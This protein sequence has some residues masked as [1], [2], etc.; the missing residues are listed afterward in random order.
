MTFQGGDVC[1][2]PLRWL[3]YAVLAVG[4]WP[5]TVLAQEPGTLVTIAGGGEQTEAGIPAVEL[6]M[7]L[8]LSVATDAGGN[9]YI[10]DAGNG[11]IL[12]IDAD[13]D[14]ATTVA[15]TGTSGFSGDGGP[16][17]DAQLNR[18]QGV[19]L[20]ASGNLYIADAGNGRIRRVDARTG[21]ITTIAGTGDRDF[22][23]DGGPATAAAFNEIVDILADGD[24]ALY[25]SDGILQGATGGNHRVRRI[26]L[27]SGTIE[28]V[29]GN[30]SP[31]FSG[32]GGPATD[33]GLT[34]EGIALDAS[35]NLYIADFN[36]HRIRRVD[37]QTGIITT[38]AG[39]GPANIFGDGGYGG[40]AGPA[41]DAQLNF[42]TGVTVDADGNLYIADAS[43]H[44]IR[45]VDAATEEILT[46]AG[47]GGVG[48]E[49][50]GGLALEAVFNQPI[51][52]ALH[53]DGNLLIVDVGNDRIRLLTDP[54]F[55]TPILSLRASQL[56]FQRVN[57]GDPMTF[58]LRVE[59]RGNAPIS[60]LSAVS[61]N[62]EFTVEATFPIQVGPV[63]AGEIL[64]TFDPTGEGL[65][66]GQLTLTTD[67]PGR[68]TLTISLR[69]IG[70][71]PAIGVIPEEIVFSRTLIGQTQV[72]N[73]QVSNLGAGVL[74]IARV[75]LTD[76]A[77]F[78]VGLTDTLRIGSGETRF[79]SVTFRPT[80]AD[81]QRAVLTL[82]S[83][84]PVE[85]A[86][87]IPLQ[88]FASI[89]KPG[90]FAE[91]G[92]SL[93][94]G[95]PG[96]GFGVAW[97]DYDGDDDPDLYVV[98]RLQP[99]LLYRNDGTRFTEVGAAAGVDDDGDGSGAAWAD[100]DGDGDLDLYVTNFA[101]PN[102]LY[103]NNGSV[104]TAVEGETADPGDG[105][106]ASWADYDRDG[107]PDLYVANFGPNR[108]F[109]NEGGRFVETADDLG[110][111]DSSSS[112]Q[113]VWN[114]FDND[115][116]ADLFLANSGP[117]R[118]F[119]NEGGRFT[120][121]TDQVGLA[122][123]GPSFGAAWGDVDNDGDLDLYV[124]YFGEGNRLYLNEEGRFRDAQLNVT[125]PAA[126]RSRGAVWGDIDNDGDLDLYATN[127]G[128]P[129]L[130][131]RN[132]G[133][134]F[135]EVAGDLGVNVEA[136]SRGVALADFDSDGGIDLYVAIQEDADRL[137][138]NQEANGNWLIVRPRATRSSR[139]AIC[140]RFEILYNNGQ[141]AVREITGGTSYLSQDALT[142]A[143]GLGDAEQV[144]VLTVRWPRGIVQQFLNVPTNNILSITETPPLPPNR[145]LLE[146]STPSMIANGQAQTEIQASM[147]NVQ[148]EVV[149]LNNIAI[150]FRIIL[151]DGAFVGS[152]TVEVQDG[153]ANI[154]FR[155]GRTPG[156]VV[157]SARTGGITGQITLDL[158]TPLGPEQ[159]TLR[160]VAG[161]GQG[162]EGDGGPA[163]D[164][165]LDRPRDVAVDSAGNI[166]IADSANQ[167]IRRVDAAT[168]AIQTLI[169]DG[170]T[171][172]TGNE[173]PAS[174]ARVAE[175]RG[176]ALL[177]NGDL[178]ISEQNGHVIRR[179]IVRTDTVAAF[180]GR[181]VPGF[182][183]DGRPGD[184]ANL[185]LPAGIAADGRGNVW[186]ADQ[187]NH[188]VR[189]VDSKGT[190]TTVA[191]SFQAG[192]TGDGGPA[193]RARLNRPLGVAVDSLGRLLIADQFNHR[194]RMV[195]SKGTITTVAGTGMGGFSGDGGPG[196]LAQ[197]NTPGDVAVD[198]EGHLFIADTRNNRI[199]MLDLNTGL[200]QTVAGTGFAGFDQEEGPALQ[201]S[202]NEPSGLAVGPTGAVYIADTRNDRIRELTVVF[203]R[204]EPPDNGAEK[205]ADFNSDGNVNFADFVLFASAFGST[206]ARFDLDSD[207]RVGFTDFV[208]FANAFG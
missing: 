175:P 200:I 107:D 151:G 49:G 185:N 161:T 75:A 39:R 33:A 174:E 36:N 149:L 66:R 95:D 154:R 82:L 133:A 51:R 138:R 108:F 156:S 197:L 71:V 177:P 68:P 76:T 29:A 64:V 50:D 81:T 2:L 190:I 40:D 208:L 113:P 24:A 150:A 23:G 57:L 8:P 121:A 193:G 89:P 202:L 14:T 12:R 92:D 35:G 4:F 43:N 122:E 99:N 158:L 91:V 203:P 102:R 184:R 96:A 72:R 195:D 62:P 132:D 56:D 46:L 10:A 126:G 5:G 54:L 31:G 188:R 206:D 61:D 146:V 22:G 125:G 1:R 69:G 105:Y 37:A 155:A 20:D 19:A 87:P 9:L 18:P 183:G 11:R 124:V 83:N 38:V 186:I 159:A 47:T 117:N 100:Y 94:M 165:L 34:T 104:F 109:Q 166:Y 70:A 44:R 26:D 182:G 153:R 86:F 140:T 181:G 7:N 141:R 204:T 6:K 48:L 207:G 180:V 168:G 131:F 77:Q 147:V 173:G 139:D 119:Q 115:G 63:Q 179:L 90:G 128:Q 169:G 98:R 42:P 32:D 187:F 114:D 27:A 101:Q 28:T 189:M 142:A 25:V 60:I 85:P 84:D 103:Q 67:H 134:Q 120:D 17:T 80:R 52:L 30:G 74:S 127:S 199:R 201:I 171:A 205:S 194:V 97:A 41:T 110:L 3:G 148:N 172:S 13:T 163:T 162:F 73:L 112:I 78:L 137:Y 160:T 106:G 21:I 136:D 55:R 157:I 53:P 129:N 16:A 170:F 93:G 176:L 118:F 145:I 15:G 164:A 143:F 198:R 123:D 116:D 167:R 59:N 130:L 135:T 178:L 65:A 144:D 45:F 152:D 111:A 191:G 88:G 192:D 58:P 79:L 196:V